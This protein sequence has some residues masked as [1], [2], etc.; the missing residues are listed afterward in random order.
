MK[1][2]YEEPK[3]QTFENTY[4]CRRKEEN[5]R[6]RLFP[7]EIKGYKDKEIKKQDYDSERGYKNRNVDHLTDM[8]SYKNKGDKMQK[9]T[10]KPCNNDYKAVSDEA[11]KNAS[12]RYYFENNISNW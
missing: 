11:K 8:F 5:T 3:N 4:G 2:G 1:F 10:T 12:V 7:K 9:M 6:D